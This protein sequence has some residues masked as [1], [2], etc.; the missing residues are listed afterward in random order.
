MWTHERRQNVPMW[1]LIVG[2]CASRLS[3]CEQFRVFSGSHISYTRG[4]FACGNAC[5]RQSL[6]MHVKVLGGE[7]DWP[8]GPRVHSEA[9]P[10]FLATAVRR[11]LKNYCF[12]TSVVC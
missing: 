11:L 12:F 1:L 5:V 2:S 7:L 6:R 9:C 4:F 3:A 8:A 10:D